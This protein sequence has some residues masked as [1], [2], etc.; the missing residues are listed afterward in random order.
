[1]NSKQ[2][3]PGEAIAIIGAGC[4][5]PGGVTDLEAFDR[6]LRNGGDAIREVPADRWSTLAFASDAPGVPG[7]TYSRWGGFLTNIDH[8]EPE[9]FGISAREA[10][11]MDPQQRLLLEVV[12]EALENAA[13]PLSGLAGSRTGV[14]VGISTF[15]YAHLQSTPTSKRSLQSFT[16]LATSLSIAAN[17]LSYCLDVRG[18]SFVVDTACSSSL[19]ALDRAVKSLQSGECD[20]AIVGGVNALLLP[21]IFISFCAASML[22]PDGRCKAFD[23]SANGFVRAEGAGALVLRAAANAKSDRVHAVI[24]GSGVNQ[25]G[26]T[27]GLA[28]PNGEAQAQLLRAVYGRLGIDPT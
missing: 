27:T 14:F 8:F 23:A 24:L 20:L 21:E 25:D 15:D 10:A 18:P 12:W 4:R 19:V 1:M 2:P 22:S 6:L 28:M 5:F 17:R 16:A 13:I 7:K 26:R 3:V 9:A 11:L